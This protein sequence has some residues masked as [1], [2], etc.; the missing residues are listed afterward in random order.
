MC[1]EQRNQ[2]HRK[3]HID[4]QSGKGWWR[5]RVAWRSQTPV[6]RANGIA[7]H[8]DT[9]RGGG[10]WRGGDLNS[11]PIDYESIALTN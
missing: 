4:I 2:G 10:W 8:I 6:S 5:V 3:A 7:P 9:Q 11:R 1:A